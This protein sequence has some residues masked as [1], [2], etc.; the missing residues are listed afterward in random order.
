MTND[1]FNQ[2][3]Y[4]VRNVMLLMLLAVSLLFLGCMKNTSMQNDAKT[5]QEAYIEF[6]KGNN[7]PL[8]YDIS[9]FSLKDLDNDGIPELILQ[10]RNEGSNSSILTVYS[11]NDKVFEIGSYEL[12]GAGGL[13]VSDNQKFPG[14][15]HVT[16][17]GGIEDYWYISIEE[18]ML[19]CQHAWRINRSI[20]EIEPIEFLDSELI[21][22]VIDVYETDKF[23]YNEFEMYYINEENIEKI[24]K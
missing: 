9:R 17:G 14:L 11:Y 24:I 8:N 6:L 4:S 15:F 2:K 18:N 12:V 22:V 23:H 5:W 3:R 16:W 19:Q 7:Y 21:D 20:Q 10:Q 1:N 13:C